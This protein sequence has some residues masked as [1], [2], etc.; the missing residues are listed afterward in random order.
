MACARFLLGAGLT[1]VCLL[2][3]AQ[4]AAAQAPGTAELCVFRSGRFLCDTAHDGGQAELKLSFGRRGDV[5]LLADFNGDGTA[6]PCVLHDHHFHCDIARDGVGLEAP[7]FI[8]AGVQ[9]LLGDF[10]GDDQ[11]DP[12]YRSGKRWTCQVF[13]LNGPLVIAFDFG[14]ADAVGVVGDADGDS[15]TDACVYARGR[16][17]CDTAHDG[18]AA[19]L[20][21]DL[22]SALGRS[23]SGTPLLGDVDGDGRADPCV[24]DR[25]RLIC[26]IFSPGGGKPVRVVNLSFGKRGDIPVLGDV[27]GL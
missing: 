23:K 16:F 15:E 1:A 5:P 21:L 14:A 20:K 6:D 10:D 25:G 4:P 19:E 24:F 3:R 13:S 12:C 11:A 27:D 7:F 22:R 9:P 26:G 17:C 2:G 8:P 18:G